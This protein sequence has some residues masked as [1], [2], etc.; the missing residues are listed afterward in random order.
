MMTPL[1]IAMNNRPSK[2]NEH[3]LKEQVLEFINRQDSYVT[4]AMLEKEFS[5]TRLRLGF[6][7]HLLIQENKVRK[8]GN[9]YI[10]KSL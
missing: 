8:T 9:Q 7:L 1:V 4:L 3:G 6:I 2:V 10:G 5:E